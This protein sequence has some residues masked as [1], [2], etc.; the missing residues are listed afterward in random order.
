MHATK[1]LGV[2]SAVP[3]NLRKMMQNNMEYGI[4]FDTETTPNMTTEIDFFE[5]LIKDKVYNASDLTNS[6][7]T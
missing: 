6:L 3:Y 7:A 4:N 5:Q 2:K 1:Y